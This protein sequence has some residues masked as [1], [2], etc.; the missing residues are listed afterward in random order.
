[1]P[2]CEDHV[3]TPLILTAVKS[4]AEVIL[5]KSTPNIR[6]K[7]DISQYKEKKEYVDPVKSKSADNRSP[8]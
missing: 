7:A 5:D 6:K 3:E 4:C 2:I 1:T 8:F